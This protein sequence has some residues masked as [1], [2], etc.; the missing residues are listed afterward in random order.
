MS[1]LFDLAVNPEQY[2]D[3]STD[4]TGFGV[5]DINRSPEYYIRL[6][7]ATGFSVQQTEFADAGYSPKLLFILRKL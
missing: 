1:K 5:A 4:G 6:A 2:I 3:K 7:T